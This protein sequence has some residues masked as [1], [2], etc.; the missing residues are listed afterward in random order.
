[1]KK[2][3]IVLSGGGA[4]GLAHIGLLKAF[5]EEKIKPYAIAGASM[6]GIVGALYALGYD[7]YELQ[8]FLKEFEFDKMLETRSPFYNMSRGNRIINTLLM[9]T[10]LLPLFTKLG[11]DSG[12][13]IRKTFKEITQ[14]KEFKDLRI[15]FACVSVDLKTGRK[16]VLKEGKLCK[17]MYATGAIPPYLE[18]L[19]VNDMLLADGGI[20]SNVPIEAAR[21]L[22]ADFIIAVDVNPVQTNRRKEKFSN[23]FDIILRTLD[24]TL[25]ALYV[26]ELKKCDFLLQIPLD[27]DIFDFSFKDEIVEIG[28]STTKRQINK[29]K[30]IL[31]EN[32]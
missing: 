13:K 3:G 31:S 8:N 25:D 10:A 7:S 18:P 15:P 9:Q 27:Y 26:E 28:Y 22:G 20:L 17:A 1:M 16:V 23:A 19:S 24:I 29:I 30:E 21:E 11:L 4:R 14:D 6:G 12:R 2:I 32:S 5:E